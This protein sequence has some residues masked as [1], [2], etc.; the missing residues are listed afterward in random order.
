MC[1]YPRRRL[2]T[3]RPWP[4][5]SPGSW[6][7]HED[8]LDAS[9]GVRPASRASPACAL[10]Q[11]GT[12]SVGAVGVT[13]RGRFWGHAIDDFLTGSPTG[14]SLCL[15]ATA[16]RV[17]LRTR[18]A[19]V[20]DRAGAHMGRRS[21]RSGPGAW[22]ACSGRGG[23]A[24]SR[25]RSGRRRS[26]P[27]LAPQLRRD[28]L[29]AQPGMGPRERHDP[30][31]DHLRQLIG[32]LRPAALARAQHLQTVAIDLALHALRRAM[33]PERPTRCA[34]VVRAARSKSCRR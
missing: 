15:G 19:R 31:L 4:V 28:A 27:L 1:G 20:R 13:R 22:R 26:R 11:R 23:R 10:G 8:V 12:Q 29:G 3:R 7:W 5:T 17:T 33:H 14:A 9:G 24:P 21:R 6:T 30:L 34:T 2:S 32:H 16:R 25:R 18:G